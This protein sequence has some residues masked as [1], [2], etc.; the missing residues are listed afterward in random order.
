MFPTD[1]IMYFKLFLMSIFQEINKYVVLWHSGLSYK[2]F[3]MIEVA[4]I[5]N[6]SSRSMSKGWPLIVLLSPLPPLSSSLPFWFWSLVLLMQF[7]FSCLW[8]VYVP[9]SNPNCYMIIS[10][11]PYF[12]SSKAISPWEQILGIISSDIALKVWRTQ[13]SPFGGNQYFILFC[14]FIYLFIFIVAI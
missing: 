6:P 9:Y 11:S 1:E 2:D 10:W 5:Y 8:V 7:V 12:Y 14:Y 13:T 3:P 4:W